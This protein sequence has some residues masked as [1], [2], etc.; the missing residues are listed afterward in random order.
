LVPTAMPRCLLREHLL[1]FFGISVLGGD[2]P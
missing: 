1:R 2:D